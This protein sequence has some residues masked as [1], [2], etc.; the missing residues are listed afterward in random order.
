MNGTLRELIVKAKRNNQQAMMEII[1][2]FEP[3]LKKSLMQTN[4][5]NRDDLKQE[6]IV[7]FIEVVHGWDMEGTERSKP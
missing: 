4:F 1:Y 2:R 7:K 3:K 5:Q 6:L